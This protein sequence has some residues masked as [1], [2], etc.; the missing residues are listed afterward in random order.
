MFLERIGIYG[1]KDIEDY[2]LCS[3]VTGDPILLVGEIGSAKTFLSRKLAEALGLKF[4]SYDAS[5]A[6]FE[7]VIGFPNP[8]DFEKGKINYI[9]TPISIWDKEFILIDEISRAEPQMQ[10]KWLEVIRERKIMGAKLEKLKYIFGAMNPPEYSGTNYLDKA[11]AGR[12]SLIVKIPSIHLMEDKEIRKIIK[13]F[14]EEDAPMLNKKRE[15]K[16]FTELKEFVERCKK[17]YKKIKKI[18]SKKICDYVS[19]L[20]KKCAE[21]NIFIDGRRAKMIYRNL[22]SLITV[23]INKGTFKEE[24]LPSIFYNT[25]LFSLPFKITG[26]KINKKLLNLIHLQVLEELQY[27]FKNLENFPFQKEEYLSNLLD[28]IESSTTILEKIKNLSE[29]LIFFSK[30]FSG[31][32]KTEKDFISSC[33]RIFF[34]KV[35]LREFSTDYFYEFKKYEL[36]DLNSFLDSLAIRFSINEIE[37]MRNSNLSLEEIFYDYKNFLKNKIILK[38]GLK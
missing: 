3:L 18:F 17:D 6:L 27:P 26:E 12:F 30:I 34:E 37:F 19:L 1:L 31:K 7:D 20:I 25:L 38:G 9:P 5:K 15:N 11:F 29:L 4:H 35:L 16:E 21:S 36:P 2:I 32:I 33:A 28:K 24:N 23:K 10:N 14:C 8:N 22:I 13:G